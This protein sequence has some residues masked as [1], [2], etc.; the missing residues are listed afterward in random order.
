MNENQRELRRTAAREFMQS[1][2]QL[3]VMLKSDP[4]PSGERGGN[5]VEASRPASQTYSPIP[6]EETGLDHL[7]ADE[8]LDEVAADIERYIEA[9]K[10]E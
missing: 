4:P 8:T 1:L 7:A 10:S 2:A 6:S 3:E 9:N 5:R